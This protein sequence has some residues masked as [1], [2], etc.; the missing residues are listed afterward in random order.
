MKRER[1]VKRESAF[2]RWGGRRKCESQ[3][4]VGETVRAARRAAGARGAA[5]GARNAAT[6]SGAAEPENPA[7]VSRPR[8]RDASGTGAIRA[9]A[10]AVFDSVEPR[11]HARGSRRAGVALELDVGE[12]LVDRGEHDRHDVALEAHHEGL[13]LGVPQKARVSSRA[14]DL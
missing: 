2:M 11:A 4:P 5:S 13:A 10:R 1:V 12:L 8:G 14:F 9:E 3:A 6:R 7:L